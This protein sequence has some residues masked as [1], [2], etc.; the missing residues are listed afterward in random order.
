MRIIR[1]RRLKKNA[2]QGRA[3][4]FL[5]ELTRPSISLPHSLSLSH[6]HTYLMCVQDC[7]ARVNALLMFKRGP[8][9][10]AAS[11]GLRY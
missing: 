8:G 6:M 5:F 11:A 1:A 7:M 9:E 3:R 4:R 2:S 10:A